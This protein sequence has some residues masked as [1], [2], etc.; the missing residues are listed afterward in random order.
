MFFYDKK[1]IDEVEEFIFSIKEKLENN[2]IN[3]LYK[4]ISKKYPYSGIV[5]I[6]NDKY[7]CV[8]DLLYTLDGRIN[9]IDDKFNKNNIKHL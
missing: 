1:N 8:N 2:S 5:L 3:D 7:L 9:Y 6:N 4:I